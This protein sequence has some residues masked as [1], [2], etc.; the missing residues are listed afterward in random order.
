MMVGV[1]HRNVR[2]EDFFLPECQPRL[3]GVPMRIVAC[4]RLCLYRFHCQA[5]FRWTRFYNAE[6]TGEP[7]R[8]P[9]RIRMFGNVKRRY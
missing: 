6:R 7:Q 1:D 9:R 2:I 3:I 4:G 5:W 8:V